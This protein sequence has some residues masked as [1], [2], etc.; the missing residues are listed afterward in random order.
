[1][2]QC[3]FYPCKNTAKSKKKEDILIYV[4]LN[5]PECS[6]SCVKGLLF[7]TVQDYLAAP[8]E[9]VPPPCEEGMIMV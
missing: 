1:M 4:T 6:P 2:K 8:Y 5:K 9:Q 3:L 7:E